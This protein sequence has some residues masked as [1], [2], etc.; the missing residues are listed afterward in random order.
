MGWIGMTLLWHHRWRDGACP[1][2]LGQ[3]CKPGLWHVRRCALAAESIYQIAL[4][5]SSGGWGLDLVASAAAQ[6]GLSSGQSDVGLQAQLS[7]SQCG[8]GVMVGATAYFSKRYDDSTVY[9]DSTAYERPQHVA[10]SKQ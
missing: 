3:Q 8:G 5:V 7:A 9:D 4:A 2:A 10:N 6:C 1:C